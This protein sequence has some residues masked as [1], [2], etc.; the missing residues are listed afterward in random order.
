MTIQTYIHKYIYSVKTPHF[1]FILKLTNSLMV[2][3]SDLTGSLNTD[4]IG[5]NLSAQLKKIK[6]S[7]QFWL[8]YLVAKENGHSGKKS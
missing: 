5:D 2:E 6:A 4:K 3:S 1:P 7:G 8:I